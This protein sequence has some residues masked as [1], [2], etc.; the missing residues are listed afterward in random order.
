MSRKSIVKETFTGTFSQTKSGFGFVMCEGEEDDIFVRADDTKGAMHGDTVEVKLVKASV[1]GRRR[2]GK[3]INIIERKTEH[4]VGTLERSRNF[5]FVIPDNKR[6]I[7]DLFIPKA[8]INGAKHGQKVEAVITDYGKPGFK[9]PEGEIISVLGFPEDKGVDILSVAK[10]FGLPEGFAKETQKEAHAI[11][12]TVSEEEMRGRKDLRDCV[13]ITIDG[14][15][16]KDLD[17]A[18]TLTFC[19][20]VYTLGVHIADVTNYVKEG[21]ALDAEALERGTSIYLV[22]RV[23]PMLPK[24]LSNGICSLNAGVDRLALSCIMTI[25][26]YGNVLSHEIAE[27]VINVNHRMS[28]NEVNNIVT[29]KK[30]YKKYDDVADML[31]LMK[32]LS[33][34]RIGIRQK[35]GAID[36]DFPESKI[37]LDKKGKPIDI[38][39]YERNVATRIIEEFMLVTNETIAEDYYWQEL[40]FIYRSHESPD[41]MKMRELSVFISNF[42]YKVRTVGSEIH[43]MEV[44]KLLAQIQGVPEE[45]LISRL[46]LRSMKRAKYTTGADGHFGLAAKY[47]C[48]FTSPIRRYPDLMIHRIIKENLKGKLDEERIDHYNEILPDIAGLSSKMERRAEEAEREV[49]KLKKAEYMLDHIGESYDGIIS[50]VTGWG[51]YVALANTVEGMVRV[52][53]MYDDDYEFEENRYRMTGRYSGKTYELGQRVRVVVVRASVETRTVDFMFDEVIDY[54]S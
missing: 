44:Q 5:A 48:H 1:S 14:E 46:T 17:D 25:D 16:A 35:K 19:D 42:G 38:K 50:G 9:K 6:L 21:S 36:F 47:Y 30:E 2:E 41:I 10:D 18:V 52:E 24:A 4:I 3:I 31:M 39:P 28:Y 8:K 13:T 33:E 51:I 12:K 15:D 11:E 54:G 27:T 20:D 34:L 45:D 26:R 29:G 40:P 23:I 37:I 43:P 7:N 53:D 32:E 49:H 22:D